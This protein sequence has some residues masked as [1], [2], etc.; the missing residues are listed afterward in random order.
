MG[1]WRSKDAGEPRGAR[2]VEATAAWRAQGRP[3]AHPSPPLLRARHGRA[4][5]SGE[6]GGGGHGRSPSP[7]G[8]SAAMGALAERRVGVGGPA[9]LLRP[10][11][12]PLL[13]SCPAT[14]PCL[15]A[16]SMAGV[17]ASTARAGWRL[18]LPPAAEPPRWSSQSPPLRPRHA[19]PARARRG[20]LHPR[21]GAPRPVV[22]PG[23]GAAACGSIVSRSIHHERLRL[24]RRL[25]GDLRYASHRIWIRRY[26]PT[27]GQEAYRSLAFPSRRPAASGH[28]I[29]GKQKY[30]PTLRPP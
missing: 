23:H 6:R 20:G 16:A 9:L 5:F 7:S 8:R 22:R 10:F 24:A 3:G 1:P 27:P 13:R 26:H 2:A 18:P 28:P 4:P 30:P 12:A 29:C 21:P 14:C 11:P 19:A 15:P 17:L 25:S